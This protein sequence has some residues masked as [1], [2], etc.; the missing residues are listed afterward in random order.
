MFKKF[1]ILFLACFFVATIK[2]SATSQADSKYQTVKTVKARKVVNNNT[3]KRVTKKTRQNRQYAVAAGG[4]TSRTRVKSTNKSTNRNLNKNTTRNVNRKRSNSRKISTAKHNTKNKDNFYAVAIAKENAETTSTANIGNTTTNNDSNVVIMTSYDNSYYRPDDVIISMIDKQEEEYKNKQDGKITDLKPMEKSNSEAKKTSFRDRFYFKHNLYVGYGMEMYK[5]QMFDDLAKVSSEYV[6]GIDMKK[7]A[8]PIIFGISESLY[9]KINN[10][11]HLFTGVDIQ[12][13][14]GAKANARVSFDSDVETIPFSRTSITE[15]YDLMG[16]VQEGNK[17]ENQAY[18]SYMYGMGVAHDWTLVG[19]I[20]DFHIGTIHNLYS[21]INFSDYGSIAGKIGV[22]INL[23]KK[24][25]L[26]INPYGIIGINMTKI[27]TSNAYY[28]AGHHVIPIY[29]ASAEKVEMYINPECFNGGCH[30][31]VYTQTLPSF[32][33]DENK[34]FLSSFANIERKSMQFSP[35]FGAGVDFVI[36]GI[37]T[38]GIEYRTSVRNI[39]GLM[40][41]YVN[42]EHIFAKNSLDNDIYN[43]SIITVNEVIRLKKIKIHSLVAKI[44]IQF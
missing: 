30:Y 7:K 17:E 20:D 29:L 38:L 40:F 23:F 25:I 24:N 33:S 14:N 35:V 6:N 39:S 32:D 1:F 8:N 41:R 4:T 31:S 16:A 9:F 5:S 27:K 18:L 43:G 28:N 13:K 3:N 44:G 12:V 10:T 11:F 37:F 26:S 19:G 21:F 36:N 15:Y 2:T 22:S 42:V 34:T